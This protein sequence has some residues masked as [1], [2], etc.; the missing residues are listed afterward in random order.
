VSE[1]SHYFGARP[2][3]QLDS[4]LNGFDGTLPPVP[5]L[6]FGPTLY[7]SFEVTN[8]GN[9]ISSEVNVRDDSGTPKRLSDEVLVCKIAQLAPNTSDG[10]TLENT[11]KDGQ[12]S[13]QAV[14]VGT[15]PGKLT[16]VSSS[17]IV[18]Y[19]GAQP[20]ILLIMAVIGSCFFK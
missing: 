17:D 13:H 4:K 6:Y 11:V 8:N 7:W 1:S 12:H 14:A 16:D 20:S 5:N 9:I 18:Y 3:I 2:E 10:C 19:F 15:P